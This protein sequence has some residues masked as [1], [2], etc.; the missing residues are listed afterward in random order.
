MLAEPPSLLSCMIVLSVHDY[1]R[2]E[3]FRLM[4]FLLK[5]LIVSA[6]DCLQE[7]EQRPPASGDPTTLERRDRPFHFVTRGSMCAESDSLA[8][9][10][11]QGDTP[12]SSINTAMC[13]RI[14]MQAPALS[15]ATLAA[16]HTLRLP[17]LAAC[18]FPLFRSMLQDVCL[19]Q[20]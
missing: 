20:A 11:A 16:L 4:H 3:D 18:Q 15:G 6:D 14:H 2:S 8:K 10:H 17:C 13:I 5:R 1:R 9:G 12:V 7:G 19:H